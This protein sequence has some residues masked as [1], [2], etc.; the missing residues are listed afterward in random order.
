MI[1]SPVK[2]EHPSIYDKVSYVPPVMP[3][4]TPERATFKTSIPINDISRFDNWK[5]THDYYEKHIFKHNVYIE[6]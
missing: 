2:Y 1:F 6:A 5:S 3:Y 4:I